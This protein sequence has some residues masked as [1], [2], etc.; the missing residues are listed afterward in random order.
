MKIKRVLI[1]G[2][3][4]GIGKAICNLLSQSSDLEIVAPTRIELDLNSNDSIKQ[5][6]LTNKG[7][8]IV[9]NNAGI[10]NLALVEDVTPELFR[11]MLQ[12]NLE[13]PMYILS[14]TISHMKEKRWGRIINISSIWGIS[15]KD[16]RAMY[17]ATKSGL[18]GITKS[19]A[20]EMGPYNILVNSLCPGFIN[21]ELTKKNISEELKTELCS[22]IPL[23]RFAEPEEV[24][25]YIKFLISDENSYITGQ[26]LLI[27][28]GF[29]I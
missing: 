25:K 12:V 28:G 6:L 24:A 15:S 8:D 11:E 23:G 17:S 4:K 26:T 14:H 29:L 27:D 9:I 20:K 18:N 10:N 21:T 3:S 16:R 19:L 7:F 13:A 2:G 22:Q 5:Y 1:T